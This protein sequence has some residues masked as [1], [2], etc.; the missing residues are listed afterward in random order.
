MIIITEGADGTSKT[1]L[2]K[3][4]EATFGLQYYKESLS[5]SERLKPTYNPLQHYT[6]LINEIQDKNIVIDRF[7]L[8]ELVNPVIRKDGRIPFSKN[9]IKILEEPIKKKSILILCDTSVNFSQNIF[10][11]R[12]EDVANIEDI[13]YLKSMFR[14]AFDISTI[15]KKRIFDVEKD[16]N[17]LEINKYIKRRIHYVQSI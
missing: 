5:Y 17:F 14:L 4:I 7:H 13:P 10:D 6:K 16:T 12:G 3:H 1:T 9:Q 15:T 8:G 11:H 2:C